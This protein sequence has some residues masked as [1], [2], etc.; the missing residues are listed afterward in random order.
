MVSGG[1]LDVAAARRCAGKP[2]ALGGGPQ[3][4]GGYNCSSEVKA[5]VMRCSS[6]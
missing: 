5:R 2:G 6:F 1:L 3:A 4:V